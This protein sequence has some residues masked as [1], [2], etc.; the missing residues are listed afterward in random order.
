VQYY[1]DPQKA[2]LSKYTRKDIQRQRCED[3]LRSRR[4]ST[5]SNNASAIW[6]KRCVNP[7]AIPAGR[8]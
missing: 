1:S 6:K 7:A 3:P 8:Y 4:K 2:L 5:K